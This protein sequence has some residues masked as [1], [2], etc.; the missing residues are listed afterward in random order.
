MGTVK[1]E[2][3]LFTLKFNADRQSHIK[4]IDPQVCLGCKDKPCTTYCPASVFHWEEPQQKIHVSYENCVECGAARIGCPFS[5]IFW[6]FPR[7][8]FG[9][10]HRHG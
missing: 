2:E 5:N 1:I 4:I 3:K 6:V 10:Q 7:G 8:G 9:V